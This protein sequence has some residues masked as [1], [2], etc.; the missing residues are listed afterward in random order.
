MAV[1]EEEQE[2]AAAGGPEEEEVKEVTAP[3][4]MTGRAA[5]AAVGVQ[6]VATVGLGQ[7]EAETAEIQITAQQVMVGQVLWSLLGG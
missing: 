3:P 4:G 6:S 5:A 7:R 2:A 1:A